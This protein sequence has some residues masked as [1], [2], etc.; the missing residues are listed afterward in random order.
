VVEI[1]ALDRDEAAAPGEIGRIVVTDLHNRAMPIIRY[2]TGDVGAFAMTENGA[3]DQHRLAVVEGR[4]LD[5]IYDADGRP[6]SSFIF[7]KS[8]W[9]YPAVRQFQLAQETPTR[10][11][12][13]LNVTPEFAAEQALLADFRDHVGAA[14]DLRAEYVD[15]IP[16]LHSGKRQQVVQ[17]YTGYRT[18]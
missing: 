18:H 1:L 7:Y 12:L 16:V 6:V 8:I 9:K 14:S 5:R 15:E 17:E 13:R 10:Y 4:R 2:D 11:R 3:P